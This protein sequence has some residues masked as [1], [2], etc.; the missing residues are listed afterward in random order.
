L[1]GEASADEV[2]RGEVVGADISHVLESLGV[3]E[4]LGEDGAAVVILLDLPGGLHP[5]SL[6]AEVEAADACEEG[7]DIQAAASASSR[8]ICALPPTATRSMF[9]QA[10][11]W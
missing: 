2:D 8:D 9:R 4:V 11:R 5:G 3:G 1:A 10:W 6:E 7:A